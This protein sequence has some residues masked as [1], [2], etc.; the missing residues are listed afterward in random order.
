MI[1][2][3]FLLFKSILNFM[4]TYDNHFTTKLVSS[5]PLL[6]FLLC[7]NVSILLSMLKFLDMSMPLLKVVPCL[8]L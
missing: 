3:V 1:F 8:V 5:F 2:S 7:Y 4:I 6:Q